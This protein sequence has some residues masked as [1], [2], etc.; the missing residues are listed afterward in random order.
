MTNI[1][2]EKS[3]RKCA[4]KASPSH[5]MQEILLKEDILKGDYQKPFKKLTLIFL[6]SPVPINGQSYQK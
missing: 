5:C 3:C 4:P 2:M 1:F 6:L